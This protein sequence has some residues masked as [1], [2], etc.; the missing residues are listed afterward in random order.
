MRKSW[1][2]VINVLLKVGVRQPL[3]EL[4]G[5]RE[6]QP[7]LPPPSC[8]DNQKRQHAYDMSESVVSRSK[9]L[10]IA[11]TY[12]EDHKREE[13]E[14]CTERR[15]L[16]RDSCDTQRRIQFFWTENEADCHQWR[17]PPQFWEM[18]QIS[19]DTS[20]QWRTRFCITH[21]WIKIWD[22]PLYGGI[23]MYSC[24]LIRISFINQKKSVICS[25]EL[26]SVNQTW[27]NMKPL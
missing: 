4:P 26:D 27:K 9:I 21:P 19:L 24:T 20:C 3:F 2:H 6:L 5:E 15:S 18:W 23:H 13:Q 22:L 16:Y 7:R 11:K 12:F 25:V 14:L 1:I 17:T 10:F 8:P